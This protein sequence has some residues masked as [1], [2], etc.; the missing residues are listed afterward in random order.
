[1][2]GSASF[3]GAIEVDREAGTNTGVIIRENGTARS[4][5][6]ADGSANFASNVVQITSGGNIQ[7]WP[8]ARPRY[9]L[10]SQADGGYFSV[11]DPTQATVQLNGKLGTVTANGKVLTRT[12]EL[13]LEADDDTKYTATTDSEG[14]ETR[15]Y[16][17]EILDVK[18]L[19][20][21]LRTAASRIETLEAKVTSL[22][23][24]N[25]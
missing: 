19:L 24:G 23:G 12:V 2:D 8:D 16:N 6:Y 18:E 25:N 7:A 14:N 17:G 9:N 5:L 11:Y 3:K 10:E 21:T 4:R 20:L 22:E 13:Q 1:M 15:V